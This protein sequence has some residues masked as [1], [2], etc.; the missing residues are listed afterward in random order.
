MIILIITF[1]IVIATA[2]YAVIVKKYLEKNEKEAARIALNGD[3]KP[4]YLVGLSV[5]GALSVIGI[6]A[7]VTWALFFR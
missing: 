5:M 7:S 2:V 3:Y 6:F 4:K 1:F